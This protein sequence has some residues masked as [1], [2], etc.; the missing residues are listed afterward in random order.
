MD[1]RLITVREK[2]N[3]SLE[4]VEGMRQDLKDENAALRREVARLT[5]ILVRVGVKLY[6]H[7]VERAQQEVS[8]R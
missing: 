6:P 7:L 4:A 1:Q 2:D 3:R 5:E 8:R